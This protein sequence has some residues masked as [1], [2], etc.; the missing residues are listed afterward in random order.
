MVLKGIRL[1]LFDLDGTL[2]DSIDAIVESF[3]RASMITGVRIDV[4][5]LKK[6]IGQPL[7]AVVRGSVVGNVSEEDLME[8]IRVR[9]RI[10]EEIWRDRVR[11]YP[12]VKPVLHELKRR[13]YIV[14]IASSSII[15]RVK[16]FIEYFGLSSYIDVVS[17]VIEGVIEGKPKPDTILYAM[18]KTGVQPRET[19]YVGDMEIDCVASENARTYFIRIIRD[20]DNMWR[21]KPH[22]NIHSLTELLDILA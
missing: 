14:G 20:G 4:D 19:V 18:E 2:V 15:S 12:D 7:M 13:G 6:L 3:Q 1:V 21:C 11:L 16:E 5:R 22:Y 9:R 17:G 10:M 8:F